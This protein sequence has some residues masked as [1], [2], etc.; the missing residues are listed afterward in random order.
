MHVSLE[1]VYEWIKRGEVR[2]A[3]A[4][5]LLARASGA[6]LESLIGL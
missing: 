3:K 5:M 1:A 2:Q 4:A 6:K